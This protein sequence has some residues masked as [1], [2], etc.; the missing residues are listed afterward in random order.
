MERE[1]AL[2]R[3]DYMPQLDGLRALAV[4]CVLIAHFVVPLARFPFGSVGVFLFFVLSGYLIT[5]VRSP[6]TGL[7][8]EKRRLRARNGDSK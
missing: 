7:F 4:G 3:G 8:G 5:S 1:T 6:R 2:P